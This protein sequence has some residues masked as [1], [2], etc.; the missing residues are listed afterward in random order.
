[1]DALILCFRTRIAAMSPRD[2]WWCPKSHMVRQLV[3]GSPRLSTQETEPSASEDS[4][5]ASDS[6]QEART[7]RVHSELSAGLVALHICIS[8]QTF[9]VEQGG[10][11]ES[12]SFFVDSL[13]NLMALL[14]PLL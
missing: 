10:R 1:M 12:L 2:H 8:A 6:V 4:D 5:S 11:C 13:G 7:L 9:F 3:L 14:Q